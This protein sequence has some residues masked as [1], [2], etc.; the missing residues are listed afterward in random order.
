MPSVKQLERISILIPIDKSLPAVVSLQSSETS[1]CVQCVQFV[2]NLG[3][4]SIVHFA[5]LL[6]KDYLL[7]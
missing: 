5:T 7:V 6:G 3:G 2:L 1:F 4:G